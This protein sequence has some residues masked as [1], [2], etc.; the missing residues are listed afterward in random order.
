MLLPDV[1]ILLLLLFFPLSTFSV[2][3]SSLSFTIHF[4]H[5][6]PG[7]SFSPSLLIFT[8][9]V[10]FLNILFII[11][12]LAHWIV[13]ICFIGLFLTHT[14]NS[15]CIKSMDC[16][17]FIFVYTPHSKGL[18]HI[19]TLTIFTPEKTHCSHTL[20]CSVYTMFILRRKAI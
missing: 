2:W 13:V 18:T 14:P 20:W 9:T 15:A 7:D 16:T 11:T 4:Y 10:F 5:C 8:T 19:S 17:L 12:V 1:I 3:E 6:C